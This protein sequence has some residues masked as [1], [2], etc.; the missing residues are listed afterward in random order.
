MHKYMFWYMLNI[1]LYTNHL[2]W[3]FSQG[4]LCALVTAGRPCCSAFLLTAF[5]WQML[6]YVFPSLPHTLLLY[7]HWQIPLDSL[8]PD[9]CLHSRPSPQGR[10]SLR[11]HGSP[12][13][14]AHTRQQL[15]RSGTYPLGQLGLGHL[16]TSQRSGHFSLVSATAF[17]M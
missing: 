11:P 15:Q 13:P 16:L 2:P 6:P 10:S 7:L 8:F 1:L 4:P 5:S 3:L 14:C 17:K 9:G 12:S